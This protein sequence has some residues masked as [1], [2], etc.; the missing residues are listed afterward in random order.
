VIYLDGKPLL[1][2]AWDEMGIDRQRQHLRRLI[3]SITLH[4]ADPT[5]RKHQPIEERVEIVWMGGAH[6]PAN[7]LTQPS[8][9]H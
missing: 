8:Q 4:R 2:E 1:L 6:T 5:R 3:E 7:G 9:R